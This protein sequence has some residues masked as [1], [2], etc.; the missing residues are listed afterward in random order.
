MRL[1]MMLYSLV[2]TLLLKLYLPAYALRYFLHNRQIRLLERAGRVPPHLFSAKAGPRIWIHAVSVGEVNVVRPLVEALAS[3]YEI[4]LSTT[5]DTGQAL[6]SKSWRDQVHLFYFPLDWRW[7]CRRYLR[8]VAP[9]LILLAETE[10][11][12]NFILTAQ[13]AGIPVALVNGRISDR[14]FRRYRKIKFFLQPLLKRFAVFCM[15]SR[16]DA[17]RIIQ[18]GAPEARV[19]STGNLKYDYTLRPDKRVISLRHQ[20]APLLR[21]NEEDL[22]WICGST[23]EG[24]EEL[25]LPVFED[26]RRVF[27]L[28]LLLAPRH[29]QRAGLVVKLLEQR[30]LSHLRRTQLSEAPPPRDGIEVLLLDSIG[31]LNHLYG[32]ADV[33]F[34]GGSLVPTGGHNIIEAASHGK[35]ILFG[36]HMENF[37]EIAHTFLNAEAAVQVKSANGLKEQLRSL[38][39]NRAARERLGNRALQAVRENQGAVDLTIQTIKGLLRTAVVSDEKPAV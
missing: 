4:F 39:Q 18:M 14:S 19:L 9:D 10:I 15:Q 21:K 26:L 32:L 28:R 25:L 29:P 11:W 31:E 33:V 12:P 38:L 16:A 23:R 13:Q 20:L 3:D 8:V 1:M 30:H 2:Y 34:V 35:A 37:R 17:D 22:L 6:A 36:P 5:T 24:E 27:P 7:T